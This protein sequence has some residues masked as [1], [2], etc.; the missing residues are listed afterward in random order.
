MKKNPLH[1]NLATY[2]NGVMYEDWDYINSRLWH[3]FEVDENKFETWNALRTEQGLNVEDYWTST[4]R[5]GHIAMRD[6]GKWL[7]DKDDN[8]E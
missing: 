4:M 7:A 2:K 6:S 1:S 3:A 5:T 8:T